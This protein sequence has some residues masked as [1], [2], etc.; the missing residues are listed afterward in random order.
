MGSD[1]GLRTEGLREFLA[2]NPHFVLVVD[3]DGLI[4]YL[5]QLHSAFERSQVMGSHA[6]DLFHPSS[7]RLFD[8]LLEC[9][10]EDGE[11][12]KRE[13]RIGDENGRGRRVLVRTY[14]MSRNGTVESV[15]V[16]VAK[17]TEAGEGDS[18]HGLSPELRE[19][20]A[21]CDRIRTHLN[22][23]ESVD[24]CPEERSGISFTHGLCPD[25]YDHQFKAILEASS[26]V[27]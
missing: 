10:R 12:Q 16:V 6:R 23:W 27:R 25:C 3:Q 19:R 20:C 5:D 21:W 4:R 1:P 15:V 18:N 8:A 13:V 9:T 22:E 24:T 26:P 17:V 11:P 2:T 7:R 14:P